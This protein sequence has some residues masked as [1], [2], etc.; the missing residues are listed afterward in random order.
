[1]I[2][3]TQVGCQFKQTHPQKPTKKCQVTA[4]ETR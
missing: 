4:L 2:E 1:V 3:L